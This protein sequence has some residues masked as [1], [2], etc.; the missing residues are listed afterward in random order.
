[1]D[2]HFNLVFLWFNQRMKN[3]AILFLMLFGLFAMYFDFALYIFSNTIAQWKPIISAIMILYL[4]EKMLPVDFK[5][6]YFLKIKTYFQGLYKN[7]E[8]EEQEEK[9]PLLHHEILES[10]DPLTIIVGNHTF[11]ASQSH[12]T[13]RDSLFKEIL[14]DKTKYKIDQSGCITIP[15][16]GTVF[17]YI[18]EF[19]KSGADEELTKKNLLEFENRALLHAV[20]EEAQFYGLKQLANKCKHI[21]IDDFNYQKLRRMCY[22]EEEKRAIIKKEEAVVIFVFGV[23][24][25]SNDETAFYWALYNAVEEFY[26]F[27]ENTKNVPFVLDLTKTSSKSYIEFFHKTQLIERI[28]IYDGAKLYTPAVR[29]NIMKNLSFFHEK[30]LRDSK[31]YDHEPTPLKKAQQKPIESQALPHIEFP[32]FS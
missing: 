16:N 5:Q 19:I 3:N 4:I 29:E 17:E 22:T 8:P 13:S 1:M 24:S 14:Q 31:L 2:E 6:A 25:H 26:T 32:D 23:Q 12:L 18:L 10:Y 7:D 15:R 30:K 28:T 11:T 20:Y 21:L 27:R 9:E